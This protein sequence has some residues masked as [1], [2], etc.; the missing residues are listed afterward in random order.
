MQQANSAH[1][2]ARPNASRAN[3]NKISGRLVHFAQAISTF[4]RREVETI[5]ES[6]IAMLDRADGDPDLEDGDVDYCPAGDDGCAVFRV[7]GRSYWG[8]QEDA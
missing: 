8:S 3:P 6:L 1:S 2:G 5:I 4:E 7:G